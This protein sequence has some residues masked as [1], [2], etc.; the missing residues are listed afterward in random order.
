MN[1]SLGLIDG[2]AQTF[3]NVG[4]E[5]S[6]GTALARLDHMLAVALAVA[7]LDPPRDGLEIVLRGS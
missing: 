5:A 1:C 7:P 6:P 4:L 3:E 2:Y